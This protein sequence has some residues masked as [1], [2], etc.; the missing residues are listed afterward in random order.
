MFQISWNTRRDAHPFGISPSGLN[1]WVLWFS[2]PSRA[3]VSP[4]PTN[5]LSIKSRPRMAFKY[6]VAFYFSISSLGWPSITGFTVCCKMH[7]LLDAKLSF[8]YSFIIFRP[9]VWKEN[10]PLKGCVLRLLA[11]CLNK[12]PDS[13]FFSNFLSPNYNKFAAE[14]DWNSKISRNVLNLGFFL[15]KN[16]FFF[17]KKREFLQNR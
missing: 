8:S 17:R 6:R 12:C 11:N 3:M 15:K 4:H 9:Y 16:G 5:D 7:L 13:V 14:C 10:H 2:D 1:Q